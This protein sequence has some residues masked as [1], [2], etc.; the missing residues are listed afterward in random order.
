MHYN[1]ERVTEMK[2]IEKIEDVHEYLEGGRN[3]AYSFEELLTSVPFLKNSTRASKH[4]RQDLKKILKI[5]AFGKLINIKE[6]NGVKYYMH[7]KSG[8]DKATYR[9]FEL[10]RWKGWK[11][12]DTVD[13]FRM[14]EVRGVDEIVDRGEVDES[15]NIPS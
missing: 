13:V 15:K 9:A 1:L 12:T 5:L 4:N 7:R 8:N 10:N 2:F 6:Q 3:F 14:L 11:S